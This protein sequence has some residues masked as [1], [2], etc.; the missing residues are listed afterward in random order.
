MQDYVIYEWPLMDIQLIQYVIPLA[1]APAL[2]QLIIPLCYVV[3]P[4]YDV[5][6]CNGASICQS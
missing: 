6:L 1:A 2:L 5:N 3:R 4:C